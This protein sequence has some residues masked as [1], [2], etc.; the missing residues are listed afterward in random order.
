MHPHGYV[1]V[2]A[3]PPHPPLFLSRGAR[4]GP[5]WSLGS[6]QGPGAWESG[7]TAPGGHEPLLPAGREPPPQASQGGVGCLL[8]LWAWETAYIIHFAA[9]LAPIIYYCP[10]SLTQAR[11]DGE[12][13]MPGRMGGCRGAGN[14]T[15]IAPGVTWFIAGGGGCN[16][17]V[18]VCWGSSQTCVHGDCRREPWGRQETGGAAGGVGVLSLARAHPGVISKTGTV[19]LEA[20]VVGG[21]CQ[22]LEKGGM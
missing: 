1:R 4:L 10:V 14:S 12:N 7:N 21:N 17:M 15:H 18:W 16:P 11:H 8:C 22:K 5:Q 6:P 2:C 20:L 13:S 9:L 19:F 3:P